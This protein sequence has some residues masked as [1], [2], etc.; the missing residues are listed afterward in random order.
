MIRSLYKA[1]E[2][3][4]EVSVGHGYQ[5]VLMYD[6]QEDKIQC[7]LC[8]KYYALLGKHTFMAHGLLSSDYR[9]QFGLSSKMPLCANRISRRARETIE[10]HPEMKVK[11]AASLKKHRLTLSHSEWSKIAKRGKSVMSRQNTLGLCDLQMRA[12]WEVVEK[13]VGRE[14]SCKDLYKYDRV[15]YTRI[16]STG[17]VNEYRKKIG[18]GTHVAGPLRTADTTVIAAIRKWSRNRPRLSSTEWIRTKQRPGIDAVLKVFGSWQGAMSASG[19]LYRRA[20]RSQEPG[21]GER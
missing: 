17:T 14:P 4:M 16:I 13:I 6:D 9:Q 21:R 12:R 3:F 20:S 11:G 8:G 18:R 2:P 1:H 19:L 10:R 5:G 15:L 7:H